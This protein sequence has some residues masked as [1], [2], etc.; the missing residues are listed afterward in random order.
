[1]HVLTEFDRA[2]HPQED[3]VTLDVSVDDLVGMK[4]LQ[5]LKDLNTHKMNEEEKALCLFVMTL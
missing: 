3:V 5:S 2:V 4:K 1:M